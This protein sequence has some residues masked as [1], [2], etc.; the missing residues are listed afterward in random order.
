MPADITP[1]HGSR[2]GALALCSAGTAAG[3]AVGSLAGVAARLTVL[4]PRPGAGLE[5]LSFFLLA[6]AIGCL[7]ALLLGVGGFLV[8]RRWTARHGWPQD[9]TGAGALVLLL[10]MCGLLARVVPAVGLLAALG[11]TL[12]AVLDWL[13]RRD[14]G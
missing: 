3:M 5:D 12:L 8:A 10:P 1:V 14:P 11:V 7:G 2:L 9:W 4:A 13:R 6:L